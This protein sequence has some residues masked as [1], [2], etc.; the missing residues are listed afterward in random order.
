MS[1]K[2]AMAMIVRGNCEKYDKKNTVCFHFMYCAEP[3][4]GTDNLG[5]RCLNQ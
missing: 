1:L 2:K 5:W 4:N 3:C